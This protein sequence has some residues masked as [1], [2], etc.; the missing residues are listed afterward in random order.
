MIVKANSLNTPLSADNMA[1]VDAT[2][3]PFTLADLGVTQDLSIEDIKGNSTYTAIFTKALQQV[4]GYDA[5][6]VGYK[7][8]LGQTIAVFL[9]K[10]TSEDYESSLTEFWY[11]GEKYGWQPKNGTSS[12]SG[13]GSGHQTT[14]YSSYLLDLVPEQINLPIKDGKCTAEA[15]NTLAKC[16]ARVHLDNGDVTPSVDNTE[17][18]AEFTTGDGKSFVDCPI[19]L[20]QSSKTISNKTISW[21]YKCSEDFDMSEPIYAIIT[22]QI[23][24]YYTATRIQKIAPSPSSYIYKVYALPSVITFENQFPNIVVDIDAI[25]YTTNEIVDVNWNDIAEITATYY[26]DGLLPHELKISDPANS[27]LTITGDDKFKKV[28]GTSLNTTSGGAFAENTSLQSN[29]QHMHYGNYI[30]IAIT[31]NQGVSAYT[32]LPIIPKSG[33]IGKVISSYELGMT[34]SNSIILAQGVKENSDYLQ[35]ATTNY[36]IGSYQGNDLAVYIKDLQV[37]GLT[38]GDFQLHLIKNDNTTEEV[39]RETLSNSK[40]S[41]H[42]VI[43]YYFTQIDSDIIISIEVENEASGSEEDSIQSKSVTVTQTIG[44]NNSGDGW[45]MSVNPDTIYIDADASQ[46]NETVNFVVNR[47]GNTTTQYTTPSSDF[48]IKKLV[49]DEWEIVEFDEYLVTSIQSSTESREQVQYKLVTEDGIE[50]NTE[51]VYVQKMPKV[52]SAYSVVC[53]NSQVILDDNY[54]EFDGIQN[55]IAADWTVLQNG[56]EVNKEVYFKMSFDSSNSELKSWFKFTNDG[57]EMNKTASSASTSNIIRYSKQGNKLPEGTIK[58]TAYLSNEATAK[59]YCTQTIRIIDISNGE[60]YK[61]VVSPIVLS[62]SDENIT[63][64][65]VKYKAGEAPSVVNLLENPKLSVKYTNNTGAQTS[66]NTQG[67]TTTLSTSSVGD[68]SIFNLLYNGNIVL[69]SQSV[70][71]VHDGVSPYLLQLDNDSA[72]FSYLS[73]NTDIQN[74]TLVEVMVTLQNKSVSTSTITYS[75]QLSPNLSENFKVVTSRA[76]NK[77]YLQKITNNNIQPCIGYVDYQATVNGTTLHKKQTIVVSS[78]EA[79]Y[80]LIVT[81]NVIF[82]DGTS[83]NPSSISCYLYRIQNGEYDKQNLDNFKLT[84]SYLGQ[85]RERGMANGELS[86]TGSTATDFRNYKGLTVKACKIDTS[87]PQVQITLPGNESQYFYNY[88]VISSEAITS[89]TQLYQKKYFYLAKTKN[90]NTPYIALSCEFEN[91]NISQLPTDETVFNIVKDLQISNKSELQY[92]QAKS[93]ANNIYV[94]SINATTPLNINDINDLSTFFINSTNIGYASALLDTESV[95]LCAKGPSGEAA[96]AGVSFDIY[97]ETVILDDNNDVNTVFGLQGASFKVLYNGQELPEETTT[98]ASGNYF[99]AKH[100]TISQSDGFKGNLNTVFKNGQHFLTGVTSIE[101]GAYCYV[102][103]EVVAV[104]E[105]IQYSAELIQTFRVLDYS[106]GYCYKL[107]VDKPNINTDSLGQVL[108]TTTITASLVKYE[109]NNKPVNETISSGNQWI[110]IY[111][112]NVRLDSKEFS[113]TDTTIS[114]TIEEG[115]VVNSLYFVA[116]SLSKDNGST[117]IVDTE[118]VTINKAGTQGQAAAM[119]VNRGEWRANQNYDCTDNKVDVVYVEQTGG[120]KYYKCTVSQPAG[121]STTFSGVYPQYWSDAEEQF[122]FIVSEQL[123]ADSINA[124]SIVSKEVVIQDKTG[125]NTLAGLIGTT[126]K[127]YN[128]QTEGDKVLLW[129]GQYGATPKESTFCVTESGELTAN[130]FGLV[131]P[132]YKVIDTTTINGYSVLNAEENPL[133]ARYFPTSQYNYDTSKSSIDLRV[134]DFEKLGLQ[135]GFASEWVSPGSEADGYFIDLPAVDLHDLGTSATLREISD[136]HSQFNVASY[137]LWCMKHIGQTCLI[138]IKNQNNSYPLYLRGVKS[139][140]LN[141]HVDDVCELFKDFLNLRSSDAYGWYVIKLK[142]DLY[143]DQI[144]WALDGEPLQLNSNWLAFQRGTVIKNTISY[145]QN[146]IFRPDQA[147]NV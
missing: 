100:K 7:P 14:V 139:Y 32:T 24:S 104:V 129:A 21:N 78:Q 134:M 80:K 70:V 58:V 48:S 103:Y 115:V 86:L 2:Y 118:A 127:N 120:R 47:Y 42:D 8:A 138:V 109:G 31:D 54:T 79:V 143:E 123:L 26:D 89:G 99:T 27:K 63:L 107:S 41:N 9:K 62:E 124:S 81:P 66:L 13:G 146:T 133:I 35:K 122:A 18:L 15:F 141:K 116:E 19:E 84:Y 40:F 46:V 76:S 130:G 51:S 97:N 1:S 91:A 105:S 102:T 83:L 55:L 69:D 45:I 25:D 144:G 131:T 85:T 88:K 75:H 59:P 114:C 57:Y 6:Y 29:L 30:N 68:K 5:D 95:G 12:G 43:G 4:V 94:Y 101:K 16:S 36:A 147:D 3:G 87:K 61:L 121:T 132:Q 126:S 125:E 142:C 117:I 53:S 39:T 140:P 71:K 108:E 10:A 145:A 67:Q 52:V 74:A 11:L 96:K 111:K 106:D 92:L 93:N 49:G 64:Q 128:S 113:L 119:L 17:V 34:G 20:D 23:G 73:S 110:S 37:S 82:D 112:N 136:T 50:W 44:F 65:V 137:T 77:F 60:N 135:F 28:E 38:S 72:T 90:S 22:V 33:L 56:K 98:Q